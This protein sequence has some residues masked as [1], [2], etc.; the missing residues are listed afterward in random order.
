MYELCL[1]FFKSA[2]DDYY[3]AFSYLWNPHFKFY[4]LRFY[5]S[6]FFINSPPTTRRSDHRPWGG[7]RVSATERR[8]MAVHR[9]VEFCSQ[10]SWLWYPHVCH[11]ISLNIRPIL[12]QVGLFTSRIQPTRRSD[13][14]TRGEARVSATE[15]RSK[16]VHRSIKFCSQLSWLW[17][18][19][20]C[21]HISLNIHPILTQVGLFTSR[22]QPT[23]R[24]C[25][26][27]KVLYLL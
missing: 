18:P 12:T 8:S 7:A 6:N 26:H 27:K 1:F 25:T 14:Q 16:A 17:Y 19:G 15:R 5:F 4:F 3:S 11:H 13:H 21:H 9:S 24:G 22:I 2:L 23:S 20:V 10:L